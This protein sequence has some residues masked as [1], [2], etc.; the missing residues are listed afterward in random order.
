MYGRTADRVCTVATSVNCRRLYRVCTV[1]T[2]VNCR[3]VY[4][5]CTVATSVNCRRLCRLME[6]DAYPS[7]A[8]DKQVS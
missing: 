6:D 2:S 4:R 5:V 3:R 1:A 7:A 8:E